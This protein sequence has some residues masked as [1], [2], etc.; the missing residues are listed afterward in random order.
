KGKTEFNIFNTA[1]SVRAIV[2]TGCGDWSRTQIEELENYAKS[3]GAKGL[4]Y[5]KA[6]AEGLE[7]GIG[8][9]LEPVA[10]EIIQ[11]TGA[12]A[13]DLIF[14]GAGEYAAVNKILS[15]V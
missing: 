12:V 7:T 10:Q 4:A 6:T 3:L 15:A 11:H 8:K 1:T 13:G 5:T 9:F 14:F 2:A